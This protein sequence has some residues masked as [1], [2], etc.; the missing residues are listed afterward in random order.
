VSTAPG[1]TRRRWPL[2][3]GAGLALVAVIAVIVAVVLVTGSSPTSSAA[4]PTGSGSVSVQRRNLVLT[5]TESGTIGYSNPQTVYDRLSGT[6][7][8]L[9][10]VGQR[11][12]RG[13]ALFRVDGQPVPLLYGAT[14]AFRSLSADDAAGPDIEQLNRNLI[15]LGFNPGG[16]V[17][18]DIWQPATTL[19][20]EQFQASLGEAETGVL[21]LG[22]VVFL[23]G[24]QL[25]ASLDGS[26]GA[27]GGGGGTSASAGSA[28]GASSGAST[29]LAPARPEFVGLVLGLGKHG[30]T[31]GPSESPSKP[32]A[33]ASPGHPAPST[34]QSPG[35]PRHARAPG[36]QRRASEAERELAALTALLK[37]ET[38]QLRAQS[39]A[40]RAAKTATHSAAHASTSKS[41]TISGGGSSAAGGGASDG[42]SPTGGASPTAVL[43]TTSPR[44][45]VTVDLPTSAQSEAQVGDHVTV[46]LPAGSTVGGA[47]TAVSRI[48]VSSSGS[49]SGG[50]SG[51]GS[52]SGSGP[53]SGSSG[54]SSSVPVTITLHGHLRAAGLDQAAVSVNF[55]QQR[56]DN[57][58]S[59]PVTALLAVPG[60]S[61]VLQEASAPHRMIPV[62]T[63]LFAAGYV[64]V[65]GPG[66][67]SGL[68]VTASQG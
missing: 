36:R 32:P 39:A 62:Q 10:Q 37:A 54:A 48:A 25:V 2:R 5:D 59:V 24:V 8:W 61:Y 31:P 65:S 12:G 34:S 41:T 7:T 35:R 64:Q 30:D 21:D 45:V 63:G 28:G 9:T 22:E 19:G 23:P 42:G 17:D 47:I 11:I 26:V 53:G 46:E 52:G 1:P 38:A 3:L 66:L 18:D 51:S 44:L 6:I 56:A 49:G 27:T 4:S 50:G 60:G 58:L 55:T 14:P 13:Q 67:Y 15:A 40:L 20:V 68:S 43:E 57:V 33:P 16:I 29:Q